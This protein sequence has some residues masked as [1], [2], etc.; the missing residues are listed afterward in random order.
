MRD[1][2]IKNRGSID[3]LSFCIMNIFVLKTHKNWLFT[4]LVD[5]V[6]LN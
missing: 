4:R 1:C 6:I 5:A 3:Y 2:E